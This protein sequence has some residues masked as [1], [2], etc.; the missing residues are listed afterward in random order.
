MRNEKQHD[1]KAKPMTESNRAFLLLVV[2]M[3][4]S[5]LGVILYAIQ[6]STLGDAAARVGVGVITAAA[7]M[8]VGGML[9]FL[10]GIPR[11]FQGDEPSK[12]AT[13]TSERTDPKIDYKA[14]T[15]LEQISDWLTKI[16][17]GV[18]LTQLTTLPEKLQ[19]VASF[20]AQ[21]LG[22]APAAPAFAGVLLVVFHVSGFLLSYLW[23]RLYLPGEFRQAD[24]NALASQVKQVNQ[25]VASL[26]RQ[27]ELDAVAISYAQ[28]QL[29]P[30]LDNPPV[31]SRELVEAIKVASPAAQALV[32]SQAQELR[33]DNW[34]DNPRSITKV[35]PIFQALIES[36]PAEKQHRYRGQLGYSLKDI[37]EHDWKGAEAALSKAIE[38]RGSWQKGWVLYEFNRALCKIAQ[39][40]AVGGSLPTDNNL[41]KSIIGDLSVTVKGGARELVLRDPVVKGWMEAHRVSQ[42]DLEKSNGISPSIP[43]PAPTGP[44]ASS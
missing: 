33:K 9:G 18:G 4:V 40:N 13:E 3:A 11:T 36:D 24:I 2:V 8:M 29:N 37:P 10:F 38:I 31:P 25:K 21:G 42:E 6:A 7:S 43:P 12:Y 20:V 16:L 44:P 22:D 1:H 34:K 41:M 30:S 35:I 19:Q 15:N 26:E 17:V 23:T 32:F 27:A 28:R 14:N 39:M 5:L